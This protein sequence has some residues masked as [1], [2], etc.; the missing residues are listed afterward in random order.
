VARWCYVGPVPLDAG[1]DVR[2]RA[3]LA[4]WPW[5]Q[6]ET[7]VLCRGVI[8]SVAGSP[9]GTV[10]D[11]LAFDFGANPHL[12]LEIY[13][14]DE[15]DATPG[16]DRVAFWEQGVGRAV[17]HLNDSGRGPVIAACN[18]LFFATQKGPDGQRIARHVAPVVLDGQVLYNVGNHR[19]TFGV[20][21]DDGKPTFITLHLPDREAL[22]QTY[23]YAA[24]GAQC[25]IHEGRPLRLQP[26]PAPGDP[27]LPRPVPC[28]PDEAGHIPGVDHMKTSRTSM[29]WSE[30]SQRFWLLVVKEPDTETGSAIALRRGLPI[31]G[32]WTVPDLQAFWLAKG[33]W[34]AVNI[35]GG[36]VTQMAFLREDGRYELIPPRWAT[37]QARM[38]LPPSMEGAPQGGTLM[39]VYVRG[40]A[41]ERQGSGRGAAGTAGNG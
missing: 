37:M 30:D 16:D 10:A 8:H 9:D 35:D 5:A 12:R 1:A 36:D 2:A 26:F 33:A 39:Y 34:G 23:T 31:T 18:G 21:Y 40:E 28:A 27:P 25:L 19:W 3:E 17:R 24:A 7:E 22:R 41:G 38:T 32:G 15:D 6:A 20:R 14:Q 11:L 4:R 29:A 13:D